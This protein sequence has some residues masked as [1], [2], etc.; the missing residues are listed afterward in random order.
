[1]PR[2]FFTLLCLEIFIH[3]PSFSDFNLNPRYS[4]GKRRFFLLCAHHTSFSRCVPPPILGIRYFFLD[5]LYN[6]SLINYDLLIHFRSS[7]RQTFALLSRRETYTYT[8]QVF[9]F[10]TKLDILTRE[11]ERE[12]ERCLTRPIINHRRG[13]ILIN[14]ERRSVNRW[15]AAH[16]R[17]C[18]T[19][20]DNSCGAIDRFLVVSWLSSSVI[21]CSV[22]KDIVVKPLGESA[23][24]RTE[25]QTERDDIVKYASTRLWCG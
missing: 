16:I 6:M 14:F 22:I 12:R 21:A 19:C 3:P 2:I 25:R 5:V 7:S 1:M 9:I 18:I 20:L 15:L 11:K 24:E 8:I 13:R 4:Y 17:G 10:I 23:L